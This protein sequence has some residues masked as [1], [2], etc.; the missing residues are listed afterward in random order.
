MLYEVITL[1]LII[2]PI[3]L[4]SADRFLTLTPKCQGFTALIIFNGGVGTG[5]LDTRIGDLHDSPSLVIID[6]RSPREVRFLP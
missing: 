6:V 1:E 4:F 5:E 3:D 2:F